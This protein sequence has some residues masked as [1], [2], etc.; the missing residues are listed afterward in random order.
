MMPSVP[1]RI[2]ALLL[3]TVIGVA[4]FITTFIAGIYLTIFVGQFVD[5][6]LIG[7]CGP[8]GKHQALL[9]ATLL[10]AIL[11]GL[12]IAVFIARRFYRRFTRDVAEAVAKNKG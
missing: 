1:K 9:A 4:T 5:S 2:F 6:G 12:V 7:I 3:A 11:G 8:Y 10:A